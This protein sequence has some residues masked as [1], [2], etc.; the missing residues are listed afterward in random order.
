MEE[1]QANPDH[2]AAEN[3]IFNEKIQSISEAAQKKADEIAVS[4]Q[5]MNE[6]KDQY[7]AEYVAIQENK[8]QIE[9]ILAES[10]STLDNISANVENA[11]LKEQELNVIHTRISELKSSS[12]TD[13]GTIK[14]FLELVTNNK[15]ELE[16]IHS[17]GIDINANMKSFLED[18]SKKTTDI[19][20]FYTKFLELKEKVDDA[21]NGI[22]KT[23]EKTN[24]LFIQVQKNNDEVVKTKEKI[25]GDKIKSE[26]LLSE[27]DKLKKD[28]ISHYNESEKLKGDIGKIL[29]LVRDTGLANSFD[30]RRK[31][32]QSSLFIW[33]GVVLLGVILS[34]SLIY[35]VFASEEGEKLFNSISN[36]Y[37]KF[38]LRITFTSPGVFL[39]WFGATQ[40]SKERYVLEQYEF[41]TA[42]A[43]SLENYTKL[44]K[45]NYSNKGDAI[46]D[47]NIELVK[48][49]YKEP[50]YAKPKSNFSTKVKLPKV[51]TEIE[52]Q[53][54]K[55]G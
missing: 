53:L 22:A 26:G 27:S 35:K 10:Q 19:D 31:R 30:K 50:E 47:L 17:K 38:L 44:L 45:Q 55:E 36:D 32:S 5:K 25:I 39:A 3:Q 12:E 14:S 46:F 20:S 37:M 43:L 2:L 29:D 51:D 1:N 6:L 40:Y 21:D 15:T 34:A 7:E 54:N 13:I 11:K 48:S 41:K 49:V 4:G 24:E 28:I 42:A 33:A 16:N 52:A 9:N 23:L 18:S 8:K